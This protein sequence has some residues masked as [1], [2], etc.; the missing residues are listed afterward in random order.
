MGSEMRLWHIAY[1][2]FAIERSRAPILYRLSSDFILP[3]DEPEIPKTGSGL[4]PCHNAS[5]PSANHSRKKHDPLKIMDECDVVE[6]R[7][8]FSKMGS[9][10]CFWHIAFGPSAIE[11]SRDPIL[12][13]CSSDFI[14]LDC[15]PTF[16]K[17]G[18]GSNICR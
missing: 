7:G 10:I 5:G 11:T 17:T 4:D 12:Y 18:S 16:F 13:R 9:E 6:R 8:D 2:P 15:E 14:G 1:G 3:D